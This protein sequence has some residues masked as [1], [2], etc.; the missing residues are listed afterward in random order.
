MGG[1][2]PAEDRRRIAL[3]AQKLEEKADRLTLSAREL[4][5]RLHD[6]G[7][8]RRLVDAVEDAIDTLDECAFLLSLVPET[9]AVNPL[10]TPMA[11][12]ARLAVESVSSLVRAVEAA[13]NFLW[14][15]GLMP[16]IRCASLMSS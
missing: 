4:A 9:E 2:A 12:L 15:C 11:G 1:M 8:L 7:K 3:H 10:A 6:S 16:G 5:V 13:G 14:V